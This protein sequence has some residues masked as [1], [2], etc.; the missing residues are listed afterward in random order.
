ME[1]GGVKRLCKRGDSKLVRQID[2][3]AVLLKGVAVGQEKSG[4]ELFLVGFKLE[5]GSMVAVRGVTFDG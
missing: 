4:G 1:F 3:T 5:A 2:L